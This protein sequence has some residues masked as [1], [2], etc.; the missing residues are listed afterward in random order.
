MN[1]TEK[2]H[3]MLVLDQSAFNSVDITGDG[4]DLN[5]NALNSEHKP[6]LSYWLLQMSLRQNNP[7]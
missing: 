6:A 2:L 1:R 3:K 5:D 7:W 4:R